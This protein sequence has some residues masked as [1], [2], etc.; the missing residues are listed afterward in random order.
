ML[1]YCGTLC[2]SVLARGLLLMCYLRVCD[3]CLAIRAQTA[4]SKKEI[5][6]I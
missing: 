4:V 3:I 5:C 1:L 6:G 2:H